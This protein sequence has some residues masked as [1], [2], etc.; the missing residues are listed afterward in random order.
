MH[1]VD[2]LTVTLPRRRR[3]PRAIDAS[4]SAWAWLQNLFA[5]K[6]PLGVIRAH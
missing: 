6:Q 1:R 3:N 4:F 5:R 2:N